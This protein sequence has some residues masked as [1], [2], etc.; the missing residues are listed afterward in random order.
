MPETPQSNK[1][2]N[3]EFTPKLLT[4][5]RE[6]YNFDAFRRDAMAGLTVAIVALP[7]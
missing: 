2:S 3:N 7:L 4:S 1:P 5:L 6:G